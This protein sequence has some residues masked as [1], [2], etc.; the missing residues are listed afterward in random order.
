[1]LQAGG[2]QH[3]PGDAQVEHVFERDV[4]DALGAAGPDA[5]AGEQFLVLVDA[6]G[7]DV[8][9]VLH[10]LLPAARVRQR[11]SADAEVAGHH[12]LP[13]EHLEDAQNFFALAE[14]VE[15]HAHGADVD[16]VRAEPH[17]MA[18]QAGQLRQHDARPL[19]CGGISRPSSF[20]AAR[21]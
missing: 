9:E 8:D 14:A 20:S 19:A 6:R 1:M 5:V 21:Q 4:A 17:Q 15:E 3:G 7:K 18:V 11:Q 10:A 12:A 13:G 16:G 2:A